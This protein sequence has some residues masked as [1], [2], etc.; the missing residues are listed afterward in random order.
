MLGTKL[1]SL[2][3]F[4]VAYC[5]YATS[6]L[7][8]SILYTVS[9]VLAAPSSLSCSYLVMGSC[10]KQN[11]GPAGLVSLAGCARC[12]GCAGHLG[13]M[14]DIVKT[15]ARGAGCAGSAGPAGFFDLCLNSQS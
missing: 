13:F 3:Y 14:I 2:Y 10:A 8:S 11:A 9:G 7:S 4:L 12:A 15:G 6:R 5:L 1:V